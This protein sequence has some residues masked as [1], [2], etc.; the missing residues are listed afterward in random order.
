MRS[1]FVLPTVPVMSLT[2]LV[3]LSSSFLISASTPFWSTLVA[4]TSA[5]SFW[6]DHTWCCACARVRVHACQADG[7]KAPAEGGGGLLNEEVNRAARPSRWLCD[8]NSD[9]GFFALV[10]KELDV[11]ALV[12]RH[13][14]VVVVRCEGR[15]RDVRGRVALRGPSQHRTPPPNTRPGDGGVRSGRRREQGMWRV[16]GVERER[17]SGREKASGR[18]APADGATLCN[19]ERRA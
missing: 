16:C 11:F 9:R 1:F 15:R 2:L 10:A 4:A 19:A 3:V 17:F 18:A 5:M 12:D 8:S 7:A 14:Q 6:S 13:V